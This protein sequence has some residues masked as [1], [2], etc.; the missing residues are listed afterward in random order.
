MI[1]SS[2]EGGGAD[3]FCRPLEAAKWCV[4]GL[5]EMKQEVSSLCWPSTNFPIPGTEEDV[6]RLVLF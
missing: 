1:L 4:R 3:Q 6:L 5:E 2:L